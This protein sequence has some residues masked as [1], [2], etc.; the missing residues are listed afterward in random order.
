MCINITQQIK[1]LKPVHFFFLT[2]F[3]WLLAGK[4][5]AQIDIKGTVYDATQKV[6]LENVSVLTYKG[7]STVTDSAGNY[8][9]SVQ[10]DDSIYFS[11]GLKA[12]KKYLAK[13]IA[14]PYAFDMSLKVKVQYTL[15][16]VIVRGRTYRMDSLANRNDYAKVFNYQKPNPLKNFNT[17]GGVVGIDADAIINM[18]R[19][20]HNRQMLNLQNRL[21]QQEQD[22]YID[23]RFSKA[24]VK[25]LTKLQGAE[26]DSFMVRFR[27]S[28][29]FV[30]ACNDL[31]LYQYIWLC[32]QKYMAAKMP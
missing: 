2:V 21:V 17:S 10:P 20:K 32:N 28:Y 29:Y 8:H 22:K 15:P 24:V 12:T 16:N 31:E 19:F 5:T 14:Y 26:L 7:L 4:L 9:L 1:L 25:K 13:E 27:P 18:F 3:S 11:Y 6:P 30:Q 23:Y